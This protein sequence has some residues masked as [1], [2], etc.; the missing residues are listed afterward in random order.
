MTRACLCVLL[1]SMFLCGVV[2][3]LTNN[4]F[5]L[6]NCLNDDID[7]LIVDIANLDYLDDSRDKVELLVTIAGTFFEDGL[8]IANSRVHVSFKFIHFTQDF[9]FKEVSSKDF[10]GI[11]LP[12]P[13]GRIIKTSIDKDFINSVFQDE[14]YGAR[15]NATHVM[16]LVA[17]GIIGEEVYQFDNLFADNDFDIKVYL[18][19]IY[20]E[21]Y[22]S[23]PYTVLDALKINLQLSK[24][25]NRYGLDD[26]ENT[27]N[28]ICRPCLAADSFP[29]GEGVSCFRINPIAMSL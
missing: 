22:T 5:P 8:V 12:Y 4:D 13:G 6:E 28:A 1:M 3:K 17:E 16:V 11:R 24:H 14:E 2:S 23:Q 25:I 10:G 29:A 27:F 21:K 7:V 15:P 9:S 26:Y 20:K 19:L 18:I